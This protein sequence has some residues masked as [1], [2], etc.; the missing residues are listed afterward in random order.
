VDDNNFCI[1]PFINIILEPN[2]SVGIC[3]IK[4]TEFS[5]GN[6]QNSSI[7]E[8][9]NS[10]KIREWRKEFLTGK[11]VSCAQELKHQKCN[12]CPELNIAK[13]H[14]SE[15]KEYMDRPYK[16]T[17]NLNGKCNLQCQMCHVWKFPNGLYDKT[18]FWDDATKNIFPYIKEMDL[19]SGEPFI[20]KDTYKLIN[21]ISK[22]NPDVLWAFTTNAHWKLTDKV[23]QHLD[24]IRIKHLM[25]SVDG[26]TPDTYYKIRYPGKLHKVLENIEEF[27]EYEKTRLERKLS[28]MNF[29]WNFL[30]QQDNWSE[31]PAY[32]DYIKNRPIE[33]YLSFLYEPDQFSLLRYPEEKIKEI[34]DFYIDKLNWV[35]LCRS[36]R[37][38]NPLLDQLNRIDRTVYLEKLKQ[39]KGS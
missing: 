19:L 9:F 4:G 22:L 23:K 20:Q 31:V 26:M 10:Q 13:S 15:F 36:M 33:S 29:K 32:F 2:G 27:I 35:N 5:V 18:D 30:V 34:L 7:L 39:K 3:R 8:V 24:K 28:S 16:L 1:V 11:P 38:I 6:I 21:I 14:I 12:L 37:V 25:F 17:A